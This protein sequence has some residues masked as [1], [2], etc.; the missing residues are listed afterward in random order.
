MIPVFYPEDHNED[1]RQAHKELKACYKRR[2]PKELLNND[3]QKLELA[4]WKCLNAEFRVKHDKNK[5][6]NKVSQD[7]WSQSKNLGSQMRMW[8]DEPEKYKE[9]VNQAQHQSQNNKKA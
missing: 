1:C 8:M 2:D 4:L 5:G 9:F 6:K 3:C 7:I